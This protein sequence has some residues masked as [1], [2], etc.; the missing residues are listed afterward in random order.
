MLL[1]DPKQD[2]KHP[3]HLAPYM[4]DTRK[5]M[6]QVRDEIQRK[7]LILLA[8]ALEI[9]EEKMLASH[10]PGLSSSEYYRYVRLQITGQC[11]RGLH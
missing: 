2:R 8:M 4:E 9:P 1:Q 6:L 10:K 7:L 3:P 5:V 11:G